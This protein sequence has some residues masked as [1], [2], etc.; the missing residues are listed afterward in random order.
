MKNAR[1]LA[2]AL[3]AGLAVAGTGCA[4]VRGQSTVGAYVDDKVIVASI[5]ARMIEDRTVDAAAV[6]VDSLKG[7]VALSGFAKSSS[8]KFQA[9]VIA[10]NTEGVREV[11]NNL[12]VRP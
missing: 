6:S 1:I 7:V 5:K 12:I 9:E 8:E 11:H 2:L 10:R 3:A 4:V